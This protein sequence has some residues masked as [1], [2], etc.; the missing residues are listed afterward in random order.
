MLQAAVV[1]NGLQG[2]NHY[3][4]SNERI[5]YNILEVGKNFNPVL[6]AYDILV[7]PNGC[8]HIA[9][10]GIKEKVA[11]FLA[12]GKTLFCMDGWFTDWVPGNQWYMDNSKKSIDVRYHLRTDRHGLFDNVN[13][14]SF[15]YSHGISGWWACGYI[16]AAPQADVIVADTWDRAIIVLDEKSTN[17]TMFLTA[18]GP[19]GDTAGLATNDY[20]S[21]TDLSKLY[22]NVLLMIINKLQPVTS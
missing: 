14:D 16:E 12:A 21:L 19:L 22:Q 6:D 3:F 17:G 15:T 8:D 20:N 2:I 13:L 18:S 4:I 5:K 9:M 10:A 7:V 1:S 11:E